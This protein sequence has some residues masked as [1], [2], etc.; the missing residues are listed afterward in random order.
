MHCNLTTQL[1]DHMTYVKPHVYHH[2]PE[3]CMH[4]LLSLYQTQI[5]GKLGCRGCFLMLSSEG[6]PVACTRQAFF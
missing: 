6:R 1:Q 2:M 4:A 3:G 5:K